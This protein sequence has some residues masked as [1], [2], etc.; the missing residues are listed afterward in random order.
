[1]QK[2]DSGCSL[3]HA[4]TAMMVCLAGPRVRHHRSRPWAGRSEQFDQL[5]FS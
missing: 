2:K 1:M 5:N 3:V 4:A